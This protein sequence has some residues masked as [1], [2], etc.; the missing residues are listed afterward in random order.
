M[1]STGITIIAASYALALALEVSRLF[2]RSGVRGVV[3]LA[4]G[5]AGL[6][7]HT[8]YLAYRASAVPASP[9]S[10]IFDWY[11]VAAWLLSVAYLYLTY[12]YPRAVVGLFVL[13]LVLLLI[14]AA[15]TLAD[16]EPF[17]REPA[18][19]VWG[20]IH[21]VFLLLGTVTVM[22]GFVAG[23][24]YLI[25]SSRLK[26]RRPPLERF[27]FPSLERLEKVNSRVIVLSAILIAVGFV[28]GII[29]RLVAEPRGA[30]LPWS[31]PVVWSSGIMLCWL[32]AAAGFNL[33]Y[34]PARQGRKVAYLTVASFGF[35]AF[36]LAIFLL[37][38]TEHAPERLENRRS[39]TS[40]RGAAEE[41]AVTLTARRPSANRAAVLPAGRGG[42]GA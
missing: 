30:R 22:V 14:V 38:D 20:A 19:R 28:A 32:I 8:W 41:V 21:G 42:G 18:W 2:F 12:H 26:R 7:V 31:D 40:A 6:A 1:F 33:I 24:M 23:V 29:L 4:C 13:P 39:P 35:L 5:A 15:A 25:Q 17:A 16:R 36:A 9:L 34:R 27:R 37:V 3:M 10:S 11:L